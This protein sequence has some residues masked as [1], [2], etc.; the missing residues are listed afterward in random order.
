MKVR[1]SKIA[2][3][4]EKA[5]APVVM[6]VETPGGNHNKYKYDYKYDKKTGQIKLSKV[7]R[8]R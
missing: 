2:T 5:E 4:P 6:V 8:Y 1:S 3:K 7:M